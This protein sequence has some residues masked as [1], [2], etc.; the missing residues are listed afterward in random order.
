MIPF[1]STAFFRPRSVTLF[2]FC[3]LSTA[4]IA[5]PVVTTLTPAR[6]AQVQRNAAVRVEFSQPL[7]ARSARALRVFGSQAGGRKAGTGTVSG[8]SLTFSP[9]TPFKP[10]ETVWATLDTAARGLNHVSIARPQVWQLTAAT[11]AS[12]GIFSG[13]SVILVA[14]VSSTFPTVP[15]I[16]RWATWTATATSTCSPAIPRRW[17]FA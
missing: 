10:G 13:G 1:L 3:L 15:A 7:E 8:S 14:A 11:T 2:A 6:N 5:Q 12:N 17:P 4:S 9:T 16:W